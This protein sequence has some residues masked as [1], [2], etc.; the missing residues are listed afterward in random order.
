MS[1]RRGVVIIKRGDRKRGRGEF[2]GKSTHPSPTAPK[3]FY[4]QDRARRRDSMG[5]P[6]VDADSDFGN[7][8]QCN[9]PQYLSE[10]ETCYN[11]GSD[12]RLNQSL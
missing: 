8:A 12:N 1:G 3:N 9:A 7:C 4:D 11:C 6:A 10:A 2:T 5:V